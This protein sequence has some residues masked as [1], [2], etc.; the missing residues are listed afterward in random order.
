MQL[1]II[2][3]VENI[4]KTFIEPVGF[5]EVDKII[6]GRGFS[7]RCLASMYGRQLVAIITCSRGNNNYFKQYF[8][9]KVTLNTKCEVETC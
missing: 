4:I 9:H 5:L 1:N 2:Y 8:I 7:C 3:L 6:Q